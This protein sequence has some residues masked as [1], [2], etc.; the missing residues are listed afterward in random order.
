MLFAGCGEVH[1]FKQMYQCCHLNCTMC[2]FMFMQ[3]HHKG[4]TSLSGEHCPGQ[5]STQPNNQQGSSVGPAGLSFPWSTGISGCVIL[6]QKHHGLVSK[7]QLRTFCGSRT[8]YCLRKCTLA[9][10]GRSSFHC[11]CS[12]P[13]V[14]STFR[15]LFAS[16]FMLK[17]A[18]GPPDLMKS[19]SDT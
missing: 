14:T 10:V 3:G 17:N 15:S 13:R 6:E 1:P 16:V 8:G 19:K 5:N 12:F 7:P 2:T 4:I 18:L 11:P 9:T